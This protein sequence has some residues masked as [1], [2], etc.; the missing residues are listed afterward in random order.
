[1][2]YECDQCGACCRHLI[3][4]IDELDLIREPRLIGKA[5]AFK[6]PEGM[7]LIDDEGDETE[8]IVPGYGAGAMLACG[9][10]KPCPMLDG[11]RCGIYPTRPNVCVAFKAG[12]EQCQQARESAG[13][14]PLL[15]LT[16][17]N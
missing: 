12:T 8:E 9:S 6:V 16:A 5:E 13:L 17:S 1:M 14:Q 4:E 2:K 10:S 7:A 11:N 15:P 3:I